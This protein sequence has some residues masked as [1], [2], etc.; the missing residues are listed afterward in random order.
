MV[1]FQEQLKQWEDSEMNK[2]AAVREPVDRSKVK[3]HV[4]R[5]SRDD[6]PAQLKK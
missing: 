1:I 5:F 6:S 4:S 3:F 2:L